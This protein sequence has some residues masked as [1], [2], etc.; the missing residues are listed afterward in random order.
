MRSI[1]TDLVVWSVGQSVCHT[2]EPCK[3]GW[4]DRDVVWIEDSGGPRELCTRWG[5]E[6]RSPW[7]VAILRG[8]RASHCQ[9]LEHSAVICAKTAEPIKMT[10]GLWVWMGPRNN[11][12]WGAIFGER[13]IVKY[14]DLL[15]WAVQK[16]LN[17]SICPLGCGLG[18]AKG[19]TSS[20]IF[21]RWRQCAQFQ[22]YSPGGTNVRDNTLPWAAQTQLNRSIC[23]LCCGLLGG[24]K[25]GQVQLYSPGG[26]NV[27]TWEGTLSPPGEYDWVNHPSSVAMWSYVRL[28]WPFVVIVILRKKV[29]FVIPQCASFQ[30]LSVLFPNGRRSHRRFFFFFFFHGRCQL[31]NEQY[32]TA[33][34]EQLHAVKVT[35]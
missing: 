24:Q 34:R 2:S 20:I 33:S 13:V 11:V 9:V 22:S 12:R 28:L 17:Q 4:T 29:R 25:E 31:N 6:S 18:W 16:W 19:S 1:V 3:N 30:E 21:A 26:A 7:K 15:P 5:P 10:F 35:Q 23:H 14:R 27:P 8:E 32:S